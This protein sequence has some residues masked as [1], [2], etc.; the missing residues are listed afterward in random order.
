MPTLIVSAKPLR[1]RWRAG[2]L[3]GREPSLVDVSDEQEAL[4]REDPMLVVHEDKPAPATVEA[5][6][7]ADTKPA[8]KGR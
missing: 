3:F 7:E 5:D 2:C 6:V 4:I 8:R 1:G